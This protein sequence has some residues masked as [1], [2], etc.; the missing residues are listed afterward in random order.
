MR[1][2][3]L[4]LLALAFT[5]TFSN[6]SFAS[7]DQD[8][9]KF[10]L[11]MPQDT[12]I[13][14]LL[15]Q[16]FSKDGKLDESKCQITMPRDT[17]MFQLFSQVF[18]HNATFNKE[19]GK[20]V[21]PRNTKIAQFFSEDA[22]LAAQMFEAYSAE[23][24]DQQALEAQAMQGSFTALRTLAKS[25]ESPVKAMQLYYTEM[26]MSF[27]ESFD[28]VA[29]N[30]CA[31]KLKIGEADYALD[32]A[33]AWLRE[34]FYKNAEPSGTE[35]IYN[36][37]KD[38]FENTFAIGDIAGFF[39]CTREINRDMSRVQ[40]MNWFCELGIHA[41]NPLAAYNYLNMAKHSNLFAAKELSAVL[42][43]LV[44]PIRNNTRSDL[45]NAASASKRPI[46]KYVQTALTGNAAEPAPKYENQKDVIDALRETLKLNKN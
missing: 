13:A 21:M 38:A 19:K 11:K 27:G 34:Y 2:K 22:L 23:F 9:Y 33:A 5:I 37:L 29:M 18:S 44:E 46:M 42:S 4:A 15:S 35:V 28:F 20:L 40:Y 10:T 31:H 25:A 14:Q 45:I 8:Q 16:S 30:K 39:D 32:S 7:D 17:A 26:L 6:A 43:Y 3:S 24:M 12:A 36:Y 41:N 1:L